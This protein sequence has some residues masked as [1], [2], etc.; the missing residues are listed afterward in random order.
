[1]HVVS[2]GDPPEVEPVG[3]QLPRSAFN[4]I[5]HV[6]MNEAPLHT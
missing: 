5:Y 2:V 3:V 4:V 6:Y 1:V